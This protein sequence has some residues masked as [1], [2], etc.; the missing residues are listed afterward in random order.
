[1]SGSGGGVS[2]VAHD[3]GVL[4]NNVSNERADNIREGAVAFSVEQYR[5]RRGVCDNPTT[6]A[7]VGKQY[8]HAK[9][10]S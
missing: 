7:E 9:A 5:F 1:M 8:P 4:R 3:G 10:A 2:L 6:V